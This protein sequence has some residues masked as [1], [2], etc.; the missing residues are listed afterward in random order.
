MRT[1][2]ALA[3]SLECYG[4]RKTKQIKEGDRDD[5]VWRRKTRK[6]KKKRMDGKKAEKGQMI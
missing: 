3:G 2:P 4:R 5:N 6:K 1:A